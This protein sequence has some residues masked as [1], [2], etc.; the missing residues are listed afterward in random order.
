MTNSG[1]L[2]EF[3]EEYK[4]IVIFCIYIQLHDRSPVQLLV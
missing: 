3:F 1:R 4:E 2:E